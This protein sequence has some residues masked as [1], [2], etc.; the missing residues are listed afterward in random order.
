MG[1]YGDVVPKTVENFRAL[2]TGEKGAGK[3]GKPLHYKGSIFHRV[4]PNFML[5]GG[6]F[7]DGNGRGG[8][9]IYGEKFADEN[10]QLK[11]EAPFYLSMAN[12]GPNT[13]GSQFFI[14]TV[15]TPWLDG[16]HVVFGKVLEVSRSRGCRAQVGVEA[17]GNRVS[18]RLIPFWH[19]TGGRRRQARRGR[20]IELGRDH[21]DG[22]H[23][24][25][26]RAL[27][28]GIGWHAVD[29][30]AGSLFTCSSQEYNPKIVEIPLPGSTPVLISC[31][32]SLIGHKSAKRAW[33]PTVC[34]RCM[35]LGLSWSP[36]KSST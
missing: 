31:H 4:I 28:G 25:L 22:H 20:G 23:R 24:R 29:F 35:E 34:R 8:E 5:Q 7:T 33:T 2:C 21:E 27:R 36:S 3:R 30:R 15:K 19:R 32:L 9:S 10:F 1:L 17:R 26:G 18:V 14:T 13:N 6:D 12:A 11:H 16:R